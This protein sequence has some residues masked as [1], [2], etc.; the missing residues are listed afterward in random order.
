VSCV[1][2][3]DSGVRPDDQRAGITVLGTADAAAPLAEEL[4]AQAG[5][6]SAT[7]RLTGPHA[8]PALHLRVTADDGA[9]LVDLRRHID[10]VAV[11][12]LVG[13]LELPAP[14]TDVLLRLTTR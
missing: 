12:R 9:S 11:P 6:R 7:A 14:D 13:A 1:R 4:S 3:A 5:V 10:E 2:P 8:H